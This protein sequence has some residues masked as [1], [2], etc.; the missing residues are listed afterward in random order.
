MK[1]DIELLKS[2][3]PIEW[4][5]FYTHQHGIAVGYL[6]KL[7]PD[8]D[9]DDI[10][11]GVS[12]AFL[13]VFENVGRLDDSFHVVCYF[14]KSARGQCDNHRIKY[15]NKLVPIA[16]FR[17][18]KAQSKDRTTLFNDRDSDRMHEA[19]EKLPPDMKTIIDLYLMGEKRDVIRTHTGIY[20]DYKMDTAIARAKRTVKYF[21]HG[22]PMKKE[23]VYAPDRTAKATAAVAKVWNAKK[24]KVQ[25]AYLGGM[26][27]KDMIEEFGYSLSSLRRATKGMHKLRKEKLLNN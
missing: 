23:Q 6:Y 10:V 11:D 14:L 20:D 9:R 7:F 5:K 27:L 24:K 13:R 15:R 16:D 12:N 4:G 18:Y 8:M 21:V 22:M 26:S 3:D 25:E 1:F 17:E 2:K 19:I